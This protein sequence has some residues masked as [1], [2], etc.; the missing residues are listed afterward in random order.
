[1]SKCKKCSV[2]AYGMCHCCK[3]QSEFEEVLVCA[4][5]NFVGAKGCECKEFRTVE[6]WN[7]NDSNC[8]AKHHYDLKKFPQEP[9]TKEHCQSCS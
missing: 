7:C 1:M 2:L 9:V 4:H 8:G 6:I 5:E 3:G